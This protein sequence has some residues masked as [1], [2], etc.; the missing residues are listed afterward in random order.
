MTSKEKIEKSIARLESLIGTASK[1]GDNGLLR[2]AKSK[3]A[4][5][6]TILKDLERLEIIKKHLKVQGLSISCFI[7]G[8]PNNKED[9][10]PSFNE[11]KEW[12]GNEN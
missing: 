8:N 12:L 11:L 9:Y 1:C 10:E 5:Y 4:L 2:E 7:S 6:N 3:L